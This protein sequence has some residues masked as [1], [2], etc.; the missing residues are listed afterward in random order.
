M[1]VPNLPLEAEES[2]RRFMTMVYGKVLMKSSKSQ[3]IKILINLKFEP[4]D[5]DV[6]IN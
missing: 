3:G 5:P 1:P 2:L 4:E 6:D